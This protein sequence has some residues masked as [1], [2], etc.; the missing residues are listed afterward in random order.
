MPR[1]SRGRRLYAD[2]LEI[3]GEAGTDTRLLGRSVNRD[4]YEV[5]LTDTL[6]DIGGEEEVASAGLLDNFYQ[7]GLVDW[8]LEVGAVPRINPRLVE[9][10]D[11][12]T[13]VGALQGND[14]ARR[15]A[16]DNPST[17]GKSWKRRRHGRALK[18][19]PT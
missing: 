6:V 2:V 17:C 10:D 15:S 5:C 3:G 1:I 13:D 18:H 8:Q 19:S 11:G 7:A 4:E 14:G 12:D 9:V 16:C